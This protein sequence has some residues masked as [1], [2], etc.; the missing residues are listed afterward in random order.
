MQIDAESAA[1]LGIISSI[2][3]TG[4]GYGMMKE[5]VARLERDIE[6]DKDNIV[7]YRHFDGIIGPIQKSI[8]DMQ[9]DIKKIL[10]ILTRINK[11]N[12][13]D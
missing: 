1:I 5:K 12:D 3:S 4:V 13:D 10:I 8:I 2:I 9:N 7:T 11:K 6:S